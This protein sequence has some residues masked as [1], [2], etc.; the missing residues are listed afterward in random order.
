MLKS[1]ILLPLLAA[2][3]AFTSARAELIY[4]VGTTGTDPSALSL[5]SFDSA[6]PGSISSFTPVTGISTGNLVAIGFRPSSGL[7]YG[8]S[9]D[10]PSGNAQLYTINLMSGLA[11]SVGNAFA[12][13]SAQGTTG[14]SFGFGFT[15]DS[16][17]IRVV[18][19]NL[20]NFT[21][22]PTTGTL[23]NFDSNVAYAAG[24]PNANTAVPQ[25]SGLSFGS[26][27]LFDID[28]AN[29][30]LA[31]QDGA[32]GTLHTVGN[33]GIV[34]LGPGTLGFDISIVSGMA[35]LQTAAGSGTHDNLYLVNLATGAATLVGAI[36]PDGLN[37]YD[38]AVAIPEPGTWALLGCGA[39]LLAG[40]ARRRKAIA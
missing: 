15:P 35:Y 23:I 2:C 25:I 37:T 12:I 21:I 6:T 26:G 8:L 1:K 40:I 17:T 32:A 16:S 5:F 20:S 4:G 29:N 30:V 7:L 27:N 19:G 14:N 24:D 18:T 33:L 13:G 39:L 3:L 11:T 31:T 36:G 34:A 9:Y 28:Q 38:L 10:N 22:N